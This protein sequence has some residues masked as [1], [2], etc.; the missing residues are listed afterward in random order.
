M[1]DQA[2]PAVGEIEDA[3][4]KYGLDS[5][6][7]VGLTSLFAAAPALAVWPLKPLITGL[8]N[9]LSDKLFSFIRLMVDLTVI[10]FVNDLHQKTFDRQLVALKAL[11][12]GYGVDSDQFKKARQNAKDAF[13]ELVHFGDSP[14]P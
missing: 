5:L 6:V 13:A 14:R 12:R 2:S 3:I 9:L 10:K 4:Q 1:T 11:A 7:Q 8:A